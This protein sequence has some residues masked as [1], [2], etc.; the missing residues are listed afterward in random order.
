MSSDGKL[1]IVRT[2]QQKKP[3]QELKT[4]ISKQQRLTDGGVERSG[5]KISF[6]S[7]AYISELRLMAVWVSNHGYLSEANASTVLYRFDASSAAT[8]LINRQQI[9][10]R[11]E[12]AERQP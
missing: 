5:T 8:P 9:K 6:L 1:I 4:Q 11:T 2:K 10:S 3:K 7:F 12:K